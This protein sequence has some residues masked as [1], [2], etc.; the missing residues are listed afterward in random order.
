L[1]IYQILFMFCYANYAGYIFPSF[2]EQTR[3]EATI[4]GRSKL[5]L[6]VDEI[7]NKKVCL[8]C[9]KNR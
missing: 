8:K 6:L 9:L 3:Y 1:R 2:Q 7:R 4:W 5:V